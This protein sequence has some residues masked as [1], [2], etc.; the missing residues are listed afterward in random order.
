MLG[1]FVAVLWHGNFK[2]FKDGKSVILGVW[3]APGAP[4]TLQKGGASPPTFLKGSPGPQTPKLTDLQSFK[5]S[6]TLNHAKVQSRI[7]YWSLEVLA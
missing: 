1:I 3:A 7:L 5:S 6:R 2:L 4:E